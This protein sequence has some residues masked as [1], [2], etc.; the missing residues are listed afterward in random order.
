MRN[1]QEDLILSPQSEGNGGRYESADLDIEAL[2]GY[3]NS[4]KFEN[5]AAIVETMR[6]YGMPRRDGV[7]GIEIGMT[8]IWG[9]EDRRDSKGFPMTLGKPLSGHDPE[10]VLGS[11]IMAADGRQYKLKVYKI[12]N[13]NQA[14]RLEYVLKLIGKAMPF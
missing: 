13:R 4:T 8:R 6:S 11:T 7:R 9:P 10:E 5:E 3:I 12:F 2:E 14:F 1:S